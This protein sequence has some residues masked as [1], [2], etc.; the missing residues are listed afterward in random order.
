VLSSCVSCG[1]E[2][3]ADGRFCHVCGEPLWV[4]CSACGSEQRASA[5]F[6][7][8]CGGSLRPGERQPATE[9][10]REERRVVTILFADLAGSTTLGER[11][12]PEDVR[13]LQGDLFNLV[14]REVERFGG[15]SEKFVGDAILAV[16]GVPQV[17][18]DDAERAVRAAL[19]VREAFPAFAD[20]VAEAHRA[21]VGLRIGINTGDVVSSREAAARGELIV[22]GDAVNVAA[23]LQQLADPGEVLVGER[24]RQGTHR[25]IAYRERGALAAK[26]KALPLHAWAAVDAVAPRGRA[27][28]ITSR[29]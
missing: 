2:V 17:H 25:V 15:V 26:G 3:S 21:D 13:T 12:D 29:P 28:A 16:F 5:A 7:S 18:E 4:S 24:T 19:A 23:R 8:A 11:L 1:A 20:R 22:T 14:N 10:E 27:S 6:C 9:D